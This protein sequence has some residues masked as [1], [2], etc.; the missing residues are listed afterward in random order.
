MMNRIKNDKKKK[1]G[2]IFLIISII[3]ALFL[4]LLRNGLNL[5]TILQNQQT[6]EENMDRLTFDN[7]RAEFP[8]AVSISFND[9][10]NMTNNTINFT[11]FV[12]LVEYGN[13][14]TFNAFLIQTAHPNVTA[15]TD[16]VLNVS[17]FNLLG[18]TISFLNI[19]FGNVTP[20][21]EQTY[22]NVVDNTTLYTSFTFNTPSNANY[23]MYVSWNTTTRNS[24]YSF[25]IPVEIGK[26]KYVGLF[27]IQ[28]QGKRSTHRDQL[29]VVDTIRKP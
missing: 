24:T 26:S 11:R 2:Q 9:S 10:I 17:A 12:Q 15:S 23:T 20:A 28:L 19:T 18:E 1:K 6:L 7:I 29:T 4:I 13:G 8:N 22:S 5:V 25:T 21:P 14:L 3:V 16:I 27:D